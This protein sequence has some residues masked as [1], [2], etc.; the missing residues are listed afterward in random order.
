LLSGA[1]QIRRRA[2][3]PL[4]SFWLGHNKDAHAALRSTLGSERYLA[5]VTAGARM[6]AEDVVNEAAG[7]LQQFGSAV[8]P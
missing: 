1:E 5:A 8:A 6:R 3:S 2:E 4:F 7:L